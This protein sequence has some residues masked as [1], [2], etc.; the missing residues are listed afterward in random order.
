MR[1]TLHHYSIFQHTWYL[2]FAIFQQPPFFSLRRRRDLWPINMEKKINNLWT[3]STTGRSSGIS[4]QQLLGTGALAST[5]VKICTCRYRR[6]P[7][8]MS[9]L[10]G[11]PVNGQTKKDRTRQKFESWPVCNILSG[12]EILWPDFI[13]QLLAFNNCLLIPVG[14]RAARSI[15]NNQRIKVGLGIGYTLICKICFFFNF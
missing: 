10:F 12:S 13:L 7:L 6:T 5:P 3:R 8:A 14:R 4:W 15:A 9:C 1:L 11:A 2:T